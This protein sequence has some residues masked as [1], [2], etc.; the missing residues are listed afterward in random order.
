MPLYLYENKE[1][2]E[3]VE[4]LQGMSEL[5]EYKGSNGREQGLW[6]RVFVNPNLSFDTNVDDNSSKSFVA[7]SLN[8]NYTYGELFE[9]SAESS[10][11][12]SQKYGKDPVKEKYYADYNKKTNGKLHPQQMKDNFKKAKEKANKAGINIE[13]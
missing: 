7:S 2:G 13:L 4:V 9:K 8:K 3:V 12:R 10:E 5:H 11:K 1:T 6:R